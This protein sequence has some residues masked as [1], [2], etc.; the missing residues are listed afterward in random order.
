MKMKQGFVALLCTAA[1]ALSGCGSSTAVYVQSVEILSGMGGI[2]PGD[3]FAGVVVSENTTEIEKDSEKNVKELLVKEGDD[4]KK[5]QIL[6]SYDT[7]EVQ[8]TLDKQRLELEQLEGTL[9]SHEN[10]IKTLQW[11]SNNSS[12]TTKLMY[13]LEIKNTQIDLKETEIDIKAKKKEIQ[14]SEK[15][16]A[17]VDVVSPIDGRVRKIEED[18][19]DQDGQPMPYITIQQVGSY[20]IKGILGELQRGGIMEGDR[21]TILSRTD[22]SVSWS[23]TVTLVDYENPIQNNNSENYYGSSGDEIN[24]SSKYPF[25]LEI[26]NTDGLILGQ[27]VYVELK[28]E[29]GQNAGIGISS[30][31]IDYDENEMPFVWADNGGRLQ[32]RSVTL[33]EYDPMTD[34][35][36]VT[37]GISLDDYLAFPDPDL[38]K[39]GAPTTKQAPTSEIPNEEADWGEGEYVDEGGEFDLGDDFDGGDAMGEGELL[40]ADDMMGEDNFWPA[41]EGGVE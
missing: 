19:F 37:E 4:V 23:G 10:T 36:H 12:G 28:Q 38:C 27:H 8:L 34:V 13:T 6:F 9:E 1:L 5:G 29:E 17:N 3:R 25:Y 30:A 32:K 14:E 22:E 2:A 40:P 31:F 18:G 21:M 16:L 20:R 41:I 35:Q 11:Q 26:D 15:L 24:T 39:E 33:G 7:E